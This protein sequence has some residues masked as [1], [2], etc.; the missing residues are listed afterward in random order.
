MQLLKFNENNK[1][2]KLRTRKNKNFLISYFE[3]ITTSVNV[4]YTYT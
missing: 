4:K 3:K 2:S 1:N